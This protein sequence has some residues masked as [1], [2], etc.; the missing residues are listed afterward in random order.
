MSVAAEELVSV[1]Q[2]WVPATAARHRAIAP[3]RQTLKESGPI[4]L[5]LFMLYS[6]CKESFDNPPAIR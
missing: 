1:L 5:R 4:L 3:T 2:P 6:S